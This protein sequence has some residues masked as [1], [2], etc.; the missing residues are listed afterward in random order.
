MAEP[1]LCPTCVFFDF[2]GGERGY[3]TYTPGTDMSIE[4]R[5]DHWSLGTD[6]TLAD[7]RRAMH[8][9]ETCKDFKLYT[10]D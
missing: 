2:D 9:A 3:S 10:E 4:C 5:R 7:A 1:R 8:M 6:D